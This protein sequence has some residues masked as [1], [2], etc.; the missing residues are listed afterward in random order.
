MLVFTLTRLVPGGPIE[1]ALNEALLAGGDRSFAAAQYEGAGGS[2]LS[3]AQLDQLRAYYG[4][5]KPVLISYFDWLRKVLVLDLG[6]STR[7]NEPVW[8]ERGLCL[9]PNRVLRLLL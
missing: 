1:R 9:L 3:E 7:Y 5:D 8:K 4:F 6:T 2:V